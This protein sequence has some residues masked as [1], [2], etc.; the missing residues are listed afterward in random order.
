VI[1]FVHGLINKVDV[2]MLDKQQAQKDKDTIKHFDS[3]GV[4]ILALANICID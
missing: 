3:F 2:P 4:C 1:Y